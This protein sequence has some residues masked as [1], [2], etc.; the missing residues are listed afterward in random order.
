MAIFGAGLAGSGI[1][2]TV[3]MDGAP[4]T[5]LLATPFQINAVVP[6]GTHNLHV[7]TAYGQ[8]SQAVAAE[9]PAIFLVGSP[10]AGAVTNQDNSLNSPSNP[11]PRG[12]D[13]IIYCTGLGATVAQG[14]LS[15]AAVPVTVMLN[16]QAVTPAFSG[17]TPGISGLYRVNVPVSSTTPPGLS[18]SLVLEQ[19]GQTSNTVTVALR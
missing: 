19:G 5:V 12:Q 17:L 7:Q 15:V 10:P 9:A 2:T 8:A 6:A 3:D 16:G 18:L 14:K 4:A 1:S 11:L 13:L